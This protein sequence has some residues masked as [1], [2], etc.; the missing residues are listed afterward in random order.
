MSGSRR[1]SSGGLGPGA[2]GAFGP[3]LVDMEAARLVVLWKCFRK[4]TR[5]ELRDTQGSRMMSGN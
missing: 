5:W 1:T 2:D 3:L 4:L